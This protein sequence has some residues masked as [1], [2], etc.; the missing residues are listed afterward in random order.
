[1]CFIIIKKVLCII[2]YRLNYVI[3]NVHKFFI[4]L[5]TISGY[6]VP[7]DTSGRIKRH[8][9]SGFPYPMIN[10]HKVQTPG[11]LSLSW[12]PGNPTEFD[13]GKQNLVDDFEVVKN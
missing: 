5:G 13:E 6:D 4:G 10:L 11:M 3:A 2:F 9:I 12:F 1:M 8:T 7:S